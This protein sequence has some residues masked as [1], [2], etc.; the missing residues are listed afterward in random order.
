MKKFY[1]IFLLLLLVGLSACAADQVNNDGTVEIIPTNTK[2]VE[3]LATQ[4]PTPTDI[5]E[6]VTISV[7]M[8]DYISGETDVWLEEELIPGFSERFPYIDVVVTYSSYDDYQNEIDKLKNNESQFDIIQFKPGDDNDVGDYMYPIDSDNWIVDN[9][10]LGAALEIVSLE[11]VLYGVP[12]YA[13]IASLYCRNDLLRDS[14][15]ESNPE[16]FEDLFEIIKETTV[17]NYLGDLEQ[18]G[19]ISEGSLFSFEEF[20]SYVWA[21]D[22]SLFGDIGKL[23]IENQD[24]KQILEFFYE[25]YHASELI[26]EMELIPAKGQNIL[27]SGKVVCYWGFLNNLPDVDEDIWEDITVSSGVSYSNNE[28]RALLKTGWLGVP[29]TSENHEAAFEFIKYFA[30]DDN[31]YE[32]NLHLGTIPP[33]VGSWWGIYSEGFYQDLTDIMVDES[34]GSIAITDYENLKN[35]F[36]LEVDKYIHGIQNLDTTIDNIQNSYNSTN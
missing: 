19:F 28:A 27:D 32:Y 5:K 8:I 25:R 22:I 3:D 13:D 23:E 2:V 11:E 18:Y 16:T 15:F 14:G 35:I 7:L 34:V 33:T 6:N 24:I 29:G 12:I 1:A 10:F 9:Q 30:A 36:Y 21:A 26:S 4:T 17:V 31:L 20:L